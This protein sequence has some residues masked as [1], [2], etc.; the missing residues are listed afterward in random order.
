MSER[1]ILEVEVASHKARVDE[2]TLAL[3][4]APD[5]L[6]DTQLLRMELRGRSAAV[7][8]GSARLRMLRD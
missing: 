2:I 3:R 5:D 1:E 4:D 7:E 8:V 6:R